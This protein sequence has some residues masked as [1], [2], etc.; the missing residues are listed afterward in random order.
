MARLREA[1]GGAVLPARI[2]SSAAAF[3]SVITSACARVPMR[4]AVDADHERSL[5]VFIGESLG[6][7]SY[8][9]RFGAVDLKLIALL[10]RLTRS[11]GERIARWVWVA[12]ARRVR[13]PIMRA[14]ARDYTIPSRNIACLSASNS[15]VS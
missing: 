8:P 9:N 11:N 2:A 15:C 10:P 14:S 7:R 13:Y 5:K 4:S 1:I 6:P 3:Q 12:H